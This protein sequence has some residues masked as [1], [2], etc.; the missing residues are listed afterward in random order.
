MGVFYAVAGAMAVLAVGAV[1]VPLLR[2]GAREISRAARDAAV[3]R[4]QL[5]ELERD[6]ERGVL[7]AEQSAGSRAE[8]ARRLI[9]ASARAETTEA[10][11]PAPRPV[12]RSLGL[13]GLVALPIA[14]LALYG[15]LGTPSQPDAPYEQRPLAE[16]RAGL[17]NIPGRQIRPSQADAEAE[18]ARNG[19]LPVAPP[20][21][22]EDALLN[23]LRGVLAERPQDIE[24]RLLLANALMRRGAYAEAAGLFEQIAA[25][26]GPRADG[27]V[28]ARQTEA[29]VLAAGGYVSPEAERALANALQLAPEFP[30][31]RYF[32]G[33]AL[34]QRGD[35]D[36]A[37]AIWERL[38]RDSPRDAP[39]LAS[40]EVMLTDARLA[41]SRGPFAGQ[42]APPG[43]PTTAPGPSAGD[44][45]AA[46]DLT[47]EERQAMI[48]DMVARL[49]DRLTTEGGEP[50]EWL[51]LINARLQLGQREQARRAYALGAE[52]LDGSAASFLREQALVLGVIEE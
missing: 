38:L 32:A 17:A 18:I 42:A 21:V 13:I 30:A 10:L 9:A 44:I 4:D 31:T 35:F 24:G 15:G 27:T 11:G 29:M 2:G 49:E 5:A 52:A 34:A 41:R 28:F 19:G 33:L 47:P 37:I 40:L 45:A 23:Q 50:E 51:R 14:A 25:L 7:S 12:S 26:Q 3:Y 22:E 48:G 43:T 39:W 36:R 6:V 16:Q 1:L 46:Q 20:N 8:L